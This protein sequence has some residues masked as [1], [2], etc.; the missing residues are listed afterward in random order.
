M[1]DCPICGKELETD[2]LHKAAGSIEEASEYCPEGHYSYEFH[3]GINEYQIGDKQ[4]GWHHLDS[5]KQ[6]REAQKQIGDAINAERR[7]TMSRFILF[8]REKVTCPRREK[9]GGMASFPPEV[10]L[11]TCKECKHYW[12]RDGDV[13]HCDYEGRA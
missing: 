2:Y 5:S 4:F 7:P 12:G 1:V 11:E 13:I 3:H 10:S 6:I 8:I 9:K